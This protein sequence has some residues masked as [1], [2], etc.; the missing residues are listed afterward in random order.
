MKVF[1]RVFQDAELLAELREAIQMKNKN[2]V[3]LTE[4]VS[5]GG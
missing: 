4:W 2:A 1:S 3:L 5:V